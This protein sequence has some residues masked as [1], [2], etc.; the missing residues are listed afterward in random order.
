MA[1]ALTKV[2]QHRFPD[3]NK[4]HAIYSAALSGNYA[5]GGYTIN[6]AA[7]PGGANVFKQFDNAVV[8]RKPFNETLNTEYGV[9]AINNTSTTNPTATL[10]AYQQATGGVDKEEYTD[11][12]ALAD[13]VYLEFWGISAGGIG[14]TDS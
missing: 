3:G 11:G 8:T 7:F 9:S 13:T 2:A 1:I 10:K 12:A 6:N 4:L 5:T 14:T